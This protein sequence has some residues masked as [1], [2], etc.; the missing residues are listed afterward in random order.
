MKAKLPP[1][2]QA[3]FK[4]SIAIMKV[5][6]YHQN[7]RKTLK[8]NSLSLLENLSNKNLMKNQINN[9]KKL[10]KNLKAKLQ[11]KRK[12]W[13]FQYKL[14]INSNL[15]NNNFEINIF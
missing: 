7:P 10:W 8:T 5:H 2:S 9:Q 14:K 4:I 6:P 1:A 11:S 12:Y 13:P 3:Q 15:H